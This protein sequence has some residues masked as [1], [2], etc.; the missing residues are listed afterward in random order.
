MAL[1]PRIFYPRAHG[2]PSLSWQSRGSSRRRL[3]GELQRSAKGYPNRSRYPW[4]DQQWLLA[5]GDA[6]TYLGKHRPERLQMFEETLDV[7]RTDLSFSPVLSG[8]FYD[9]ER[10]EQIKKAIGQYDTDA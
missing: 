4:Y 3:V 6:K 10:L 2:I 9:T 7:F 5:Y 1:P 8:D